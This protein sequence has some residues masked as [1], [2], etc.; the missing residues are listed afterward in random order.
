MRPKKSSNDVVGRAEFATPVAD[1]ASGETLVTPKSWQLCVWSDPC[2]ADCVRPVFYRSSR[3]CD[4]LGQGQSGGFSY[5]AEY[6]FAWPGT[7]RRH[8]EQVFEI[9]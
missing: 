8:I 6:C 9:C 4:L 5:F 7:H 2:R 1:E 3:G